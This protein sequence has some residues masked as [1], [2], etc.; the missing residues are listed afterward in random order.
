MPIQPLEDYTFH[1][2]DLI[3]SERSSGEGYHALHRNLLGA[4]H[5]NC[6]VEA[7]HGNKLDKCIIDTILWNDTIKVGHGIGNYISAELAIG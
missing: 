6:K 4:V 7:C 1:L 2:D 3:I 5:F